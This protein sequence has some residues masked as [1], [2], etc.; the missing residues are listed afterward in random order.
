MNTVSDLR[1]ITLFSSLS[2]DTLT[3]LAQFAIQRKYSS[4]EI[5]LHETDPSRG[6]YF[7]A[8]GQVQVFRLSLAGREQILVN[9]KS[10]DAFNTV[11]LF[12]TE[13]I[14]HASAR[15]LTDARLYLLR[16][17][18]FLRLTETSPDLAMNVLR[19]FA[20]KLTHLTGLV[21]QLSLHSI[22]GRL[23]RFLIEQ[24]N[25]GE[26][27][28]RW[29]QDE[30]AAHLGTV[31]DMVGRTLRAFTDAG[32]IRRERNRVIL[33]DRTALEAEAEQ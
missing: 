33:L 31:R 1:Q 30:I 19:D 25:Q 29:T 28:G 11:P 9:L 5:I 4:G 7:I 8:A 21:E 2:E 14:N 15:A 10:G 22:R 12:E 32:M 6:A 18:D 16:K 24:A 23:A 20:G 27:A 26:V 3:R 17:E 13:S